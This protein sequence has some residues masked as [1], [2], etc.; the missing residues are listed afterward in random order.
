MKGLWK[1][2]L[3]SSIIDRPKKE[4]SVNASGGAVHAHFTAA[5]QAGHSHVSRWVLVPR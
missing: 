5:R 1:G 4:G 3:T 2:N